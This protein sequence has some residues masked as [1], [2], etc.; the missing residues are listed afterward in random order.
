MVGDYK[1]EQVGDFVGNPQCIKWRNDQGYS[2]GGSGLCQ[3]AKEMA[4][5]WGYSWKK[6]SVLMMP[7]CPT[8]LLSLCFSSVVRVPYGAPEALFRARC[9]N[10]PEWLKSPGNQAIGINF[11]PLAL[12]ESLRAAT[13]DWPPD[14]V[15]RFIAPDGWWAIETPLRARFCVLIHPVQSTLGAE[16]PA[17]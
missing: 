3:L 9:R 4:F 6:H 8:F 7:N 13:G 11:S 10:R 15:A 16:R 2:H 1:S 14:G 17:S 5:G 12:P